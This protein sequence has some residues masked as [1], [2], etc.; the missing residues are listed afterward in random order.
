MF[1]LGAAAELRQG[2]QRFGT[3]ISMNWVF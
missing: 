2:R 1:K 3:D